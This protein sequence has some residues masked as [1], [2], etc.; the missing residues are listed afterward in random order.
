MTQQAAPKEGIQSLALARLVGVTRFTH[1]VTD[2]DLYALKES[3]EAAARLRVFPGGAD[4][5]RVGL[6]GEVYSNGSSGYAFI[7]AR[8]DRHSDGDNGEGQLD[9]DMHC[10]FELSTTNGH[11][12]RTLTLEGIEL[13]DPATGSSCLVH[14]HDRKLF[15]LL[16]RWCEESFDCDEL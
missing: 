4:L 13:Q 16:T 2:A 3:L 7:A 11:G 5:E 6:T 12:E 15:G 1:P 9:F 8:W 14:V 10:R